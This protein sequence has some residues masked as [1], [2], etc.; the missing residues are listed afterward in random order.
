L[1]ATVGAVLLLLPY[2]FIFLTFRFHTFL[3]QIYSGLLS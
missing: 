3:A 1:T 2:L